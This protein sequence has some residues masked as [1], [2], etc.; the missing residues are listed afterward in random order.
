MNDAL[1]VADETHSGRRVRTLELNRPDKR[2]C[3]NLDL[4][5]RLTR[6]LHESRDAFVVLCGRGS[7]FCTG[8]DLQELHEHRTADKHLGLL[9]DLLEALAA[10]PRPTIA[11]VRGM[12]NGGGVALAC[13]ADATIASSEARFK[14][15]GNAALRP[16]VQAVVPIIADRRRIEPASVRLL[17]GVNCTAERALRARLIDT[18]EDGPDFARLW[19]TARLVLDCKGVAEPAAARRRLGPQALLEARRLCRE[20]AVPATLTPLMELLANRYGTA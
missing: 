6:A 1:I 18:I 19:Q 17:I 13:C 10:H 4:L 12:A 7:A 11:I 14:L 8:L 3:L 15:P 20:A 16:L 2:N 5:G 9:M